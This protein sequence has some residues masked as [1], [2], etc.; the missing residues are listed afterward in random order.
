MSIIFLSSVNGGK[1]KIVVNN[2]TREEV[3]QWAEHL[4]TRS[5]HE[6]IRFNKPWHTEN[7]SIQGIWTPFTNKDSKLNVTEFPSEELSRF[8]T[9]IPSATDRLLEMAKTLRVENVQIEEKEEEQTV[10]AAKNSW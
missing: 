6:I 9:G 2:Y 8:N 5:G 1:E 10:Q 3:C 4:R 7:P